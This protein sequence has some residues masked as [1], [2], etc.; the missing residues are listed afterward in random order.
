MTSNS[1]KLTITFDNRPNQGGFPTLWGF[2]CHIQTD[3]RTLLF[4]T[5]SNGR[6]LV[7][8]M[9]KLELDLTAVDTLFL[10][11]PHWDHIGGLDS[12]LEQNPH[13]DIFVPASFS[14]HL[15]NDLRMLA[16]SVTVIDKVPIQILPC[17]WSTGMMGEVGEQALVLDTPSGIIVVT[18]CA[19][20]GVEHIA[21]RA[22]E[23]AEKPIL[24][25]IGGFHLMYASTN[26]IRSVIAQL[27]ALGVQNVCPTHCSGD[28]AIAMFAEHF[29]ERYIPGGTGQSIEI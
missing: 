15:I 5:G 27:D 10:S 26:Q 11:H 29:G 16:K 24:L 12:V 20:P 3:Q 4:D 9:E 1:T 22:I 21:Q 7:Q 14:K 18:G 25:L 19:H 23:I 17:C 13:V 8:N 6:V 28:E 2:S